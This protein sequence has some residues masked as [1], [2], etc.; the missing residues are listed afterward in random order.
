MNWG[1][2]RRELHDLETQRNLP[3]DFAGNREHIS[4]IISCGNMFLGVR[5][6]LAG[7]IWVGFMLEFTFTFHR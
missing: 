1:W 6:L 2:E 4:T 5:V 3:T 7:E